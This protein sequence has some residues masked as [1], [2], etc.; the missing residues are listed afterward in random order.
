MVKVADFGL[1]KMTKSGESGLTQS[2]MAMG[3]LHYMAP[4]ALML[5]SEVD[6][7]ADIYAVGV[8]LY[9]MLTG[10]VPHGM[11]ELPSMQVAGLDPRYDAI[12]AQAMRED[13]DIRYQSVRGLRGDLDSILTQPVVQ[14][15]PQATQAAAAVPAQAG[16]PSTQP[17]RTAGQPYRPPQSQMVMRSQP[18]KN[19]PLPRVVVVAVLGVAAWFVLGRSKPAPPE[20]KLTGLTAAGADS[21]NT[22]SIPAAA[23]SGSSTTHPAAATK[24]QASGNSGEVRDSQS[25]K[26]GARATLVSTNWMDVMPLID[27]V[28][29]AQLPHRLSWTRTPAGFE[30]KRVDDQRIY[31][32]CLQIP[33]P[34][35]SS[36]A[37][38]AEVTAGSAYSVGITVPVGDG[39]RTTCWI[40]ADRKVAGIGKI[41]GKDPWDKTLDSGCASAFQLEAGRRYKLDVEV[42]RA[43]E[44][45]NIQFSVDGKLVGAYRGPSSR[46]SVCSCWNKG[47]DP[48]LV[49]FGANDT[50]TFHAVKI[51]ALAA[52]DSPELR[53]GLVSWWKADNDARDAVGSNHGTLVGAASFTDGFYGKAFQLDGGYVEVPDSAALQFGP[54]SKFTVTLWAYRTSENRP[55]HLFG[56]RS[57]KRGDDA[58]KGYQLGFSGSVPQ[59]ALNEWA[60]WTVV[61]D[62]SRQSVYINGGP[63]STYG[64]ISSGGPVPFRIGRSGDYESFKGKVDD[65][66][67]YDRAMTPREIQALYEWRE[68]KTEP[69]KAELSTI[70]ELAALQQQL[71]KLQAERVTAAFEAD[72]A[73]LN[74]GYLGGLDREV[75]KERAAG[76]LD[77]VL[78]LEAEKKHITDK[79]PL[80]V[81]DATGTSS[82][83]KNLRSIYREAHA[84]LE[85]ARITNS[86]TLTDSLVLRLQSLE[87]EL[88]KQNRIADAKVVHEYREKLSAPEINVAFSITNPFINSMGMKFVPVPSTEVLF[89]TTLTRGNDYNAFEVETKGS[90]PNGPVAESDFQT[91]KRESRLF[92]V[93]TLS[94][95]DAKAF[96]DWLSKK[97]GRTYRLPTDREWSVAVGIGGLESKNATPEELNGRLANLYP[98]GSQWPPPNGFGNYSD[99]AYRLFCQKNKYTGGPTIKGYTDGEIAISPVEAFKTN[100]F[101]L[102]D[103][104]GNLWQW[105]D[106]WYDAAKTQHH[107]RGGSW[108]ESDKAKLLASAR[109]PHELGFRED[110]TDKSSFRCVLVTSSI[111]GVSSTTA[112]QSPAV[113]TPMITPPAESAAQPQPANPSATVVFTNTLGMKFVAVP[114]T[115]VKMCIHETRKV[116]FA[117][118]AFAVAAT[119]ASWKNVRIQD[120]LTVSASDDHPVVNV[121]WEEATAFCAWLST[122]EGKTYRLPTD[123]EWS[124]AVGIGPR[125]TSTGTPESRS[126]KLKDIY[127]W[128]TQWPPPASAGNYADATLAGRSPT[129]KT[130]PGFTDGH[131]TTAPVMSFP[132]NALGIH[133]LGGNVWEFCS[134]AFSTSSKVH[135][136]RGGSWGDAEQHWLLS[137]SRDPFEQTGRYYIVG[138]R[139][140]LEDATGR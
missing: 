4:E 82:T 87:S 124:T 135:V 72:V 97:E 125:E 40:V 119:N 114:G 36:Y 62:G 107:L 128:G 139:C 17:H 80:P 89:C 127:P 3:T 46:L 122:K 44:G 15:D 92:P 18:K 102:H 81:T 134:D 41:D 42:R 66:R 32:G 115:K 1:A 101:G 8:M 49:D 84:K 51:R 56:K 112:S 43:P 71:T 6:H 5:G 93:S 26:P 16:R 61:Y 13:R 64:K 88:T 30:C 86:K 14:A 138:F 137:S 21:G 20:S 74:S 65:V 110:K 117:N 24:E 67:V 103:M 59:F 2:G 96:C 31:S 38:E 120:G 11:F 10:K 123:R 70:P 68:L 130:I 118:F 94:W 85:A 111:K 35:P 34:V 73:K 108:D 133:D 12:I 45:V 29:N 136:L 98:W 99:E 78:A 27:P 47:G 28:Q 75:A 90:K 60:F 113:L 104:G 37:V 54:D 53:R 95:E 116:D 129:Q 77:G 140:V 25:A 55:F 19:S 48:A 105:C 69:A 121:S 132:P 106:D 79:Q 109:W 50:A 52:P 91:P 83:L 57:D 58:T 22:Q 100:K 131:A 63:L 7:R 126:E 39:A 23:A 33:V 76:R 9:Q